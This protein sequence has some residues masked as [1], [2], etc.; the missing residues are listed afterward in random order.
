[1]SLSGNSW[2]HCRL[3]RAH[4]R[5]HKSGPRLRYLPRA[6]FNGSQACIHPHTCRHAH[7]PTLIDVSCKLIH[8]M[9]RSADEYMHSHSHRY[10]HYYYMGECTCNLWTTR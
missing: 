6:R 4:S 9:T 3:Y 10:A 1:M 8:I 7:T 5:T 2:R